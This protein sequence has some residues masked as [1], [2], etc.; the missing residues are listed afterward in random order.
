M[1]R[2]LL[3]LLLTYLPLVAMA[4][5][6]GVEH[7]LAQMTLEEKVGQLTM[8]HI[9]D[10]P[11]GA[12][13]N[14]QSQKHLAM[15]D[16][17]AVIG[18]GGA[19][20]TR[21]LQRLVVEGS[22]LHI[23]LLFSLDVIHGFCTMF[24]VP[25]AEASAWEPDLTQRT[26]H[27]AAVEAT[28]SGVHWTLAPMIDITR[29]PRWGRV[30]EGSGED[31][32]LGSAMTRAR[33][34]GFHGDGPTSTAFMLTT[35]KHFVAYGA[36]EAGRDYNTV[37]LSQRTLWEVYLPPFQ[38]AVQASVDAIMPAFNELEGLPMASNQALLDG[39]LRRRWGFSGMIVSDHGALSELITHG[40]AATPLDA[41]RQAIG[42]GLEVEM[43][44][45]FFR[46]N[47]PYLVRNGQ[48]SMA[49]VDNAVRHVLKAKQR[50]GLFD[51]P[52]RYS[53]ATRQRLLSQTPQARALAREAAQ[54]SI[55]LLK[56]A[57]SLL[58]LSKD[59]QKILVVGSLATDVAA[60]LENC[61]AAERP[62]GAISIL[63]GIQNA[64]SPA[65]R[66]IYVP[67]ASPSSQDTQGIAAAQNAAQEADVIVA[68]LGETSN[69]SG[70]A[71]SRASLDLPGAQNAL[72]R[73]LLKTGKPVV[74]ILMN[75]RPLALT[76]TVERAPAIIESWFLGTE[77]GNAVAD[78]LFGDTNPSGKLP[79]TFPRSVGQVPIY[80]AHKN[81]GRPVVDQDDSWT[82][83]YIDQPSTPLYPFG[84]GLSY[85]T[86]SYGTPQLS[87]TR[88]G[89]SQRLTV[90]TSVTNTG[91]RAGDE[92]VQL[93]L[94]DNVASVT[95]PVRQLRGFRK[96]H[97]RPGQTQEV[98]FTLDEN[99][100]AVLDAD[101]E[102]RVEAGTFTLF[103]G[104]DST[105]DNRAHFEVT[106]SRKLSVSGQSVSSSGS[107]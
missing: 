11:D 53:D 90:T 18:A 32:F 64:A 22:R 30:V 45:Q 47:L 42:A 10:T 88:L 40:I 43:A 38:A 24:P 62:I 21:Q 101:F 81:T 93:Y 36:A 31:P 65:S 76:G 23:P 52:Y 74:V 95:R 91:S 98:V 70:E 99:D 63:Q 67:G 78:V 66:V 104:G 14:L 20:K 44:N 29:D 92:I 82:S 3:I 84:F 100:F 33:I 17:G 49:T 26:A 58:P 86:F 13:I 106:D 107:N 94:R 6:D 46:Q 59:L 72:L 48:V 34:K 4:Q 16:V 27:A 79:M 56:N 57:D 2:R 55:V 35:A 69:M 103:V 39:V 25:L 8:L 37:D 77:A 15:T 71:N 50:L 5:D 68:V 102:P 61:M 12:I 60:S 19:E 9:V 85:T 75:G 83:R 1:E 96:V 54:K 28:A 7:L 89:S 41:S 87:N 80:Y 51:D 97:L 105:T 73:A